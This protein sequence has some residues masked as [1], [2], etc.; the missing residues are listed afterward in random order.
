MMNHPAVFFIFTSL[1]AL[2]NDVFSEIILQ[3]AT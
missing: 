1:F 2:Y 3:V